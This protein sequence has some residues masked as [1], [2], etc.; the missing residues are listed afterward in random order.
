VA[1]FQFSEHPYYRHALGRGF[2]ILDGDRPIARLAAFV[3]L[4]F[5]HE[6]R[7]KVGFLGFFAALPAAPAQVWTSL[8]DAARDWLLKEG[9]SAVLAPVEQDFWRGM[10]TQTSALDP[11]ISVLKGLGWGEVVRGYQVRVELETLVWPPEFEGRAEVAQQATRAQLLPQ[12]DWIRGSPGLGLVEA[13]AR[14]AQRRT[15]LERDLKIRSLVL[16]SVPAPGVEEVGMPWNRVPNAADWVCWRDEVAPTCMELDVQVAGELAGWLQ[17]R[18]NSAT[19]WSVQHV[20]ISPAYR[21]FDLLPWCIVATSRWAMDAGVLSLEWFAADASSTLGRTLEQV[22]EGAKREV[23]VL[24]GAPL[25]GRRKG[26]G[27]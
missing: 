7:E 3:D 8:T 18:R 16:G 26:F 2:L 10:G 12:K 19:D 20:E 15:R 9:M 13:V 6:R 1:L 22:F 21:D 27:P 23:R 24:L 4:D 17:I 11:L 14:P 5:V 25:A